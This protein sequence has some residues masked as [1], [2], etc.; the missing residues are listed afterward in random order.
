[1]DTCY[2]CKKSTVKYFLSIL[3]CLTFA[4]C[5]TYRN[6]PIQ[7]GKLLGVL[8]IRDGRVYY[9]FGNT[10]PKTSALDVYRQSRRWVAFHIADPKQAL[11]LGDSQT[12]DVIGSG[13]IS[14]IKM[15]K[16]SIYTFGP[17]E[18]AVTIEARPNGYR[19]ALGNFTLVRPIPSITKGISLESPTPLPL[20]QLRT[21]F[22]ELDRRINDLVV[23]F[24]SFVTDQ[25]KPT[26]P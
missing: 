16:S 20:K 8:P 14:A 22:E 12:L 24:D 15:D 26:T 23:S 13:S 10:I 7:D 17:V 3:I 1:M 5:I 21:L 2:Y 25:T 6:I 4:S 9:D 18:Y 19:M 11:S